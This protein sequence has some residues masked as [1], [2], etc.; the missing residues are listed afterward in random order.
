MQAAVQRS[1]VHEL[2]PQ[3][4]VKQCLTKAVLTSVT[5]VCAYGVLLLQEALALGKPLI[6]VVNTLLM[7]NHQC[8][9]AEAMAERR[10]AVA[11]T[12]YEL[13]SVLQGDALKQLQ[14]Y[15]PPPSPYT[16][17]HALNQEMA[18]P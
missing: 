10:Y 4:D 6:T 5:T 9:I 16:F 14:P 11:T 18:L 13:L 15:P 17:V 12:P 3:Y 2:Q 1:L 8:E 7:H